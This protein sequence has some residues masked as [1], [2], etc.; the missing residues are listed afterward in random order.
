M[1]YIQ[2]YCIAALIGTIVLAA[3]YFLKRNY[4]T[5]NNRLFFAMI[6]INLATSALNIVSIHTI[7]YPER[8]SP[9]VRL[10]VNLVYLWLYNLLAAVF[11]LY[12]DSLTRIP[13]FKKP[14]RIYAYFVTAL[15]AVLVLLSPM[16]HLIAWFDEA[17]VYRRGVLHPLLYVTAYAAIF[18]AL[19]LFIASRKKFSR[20]QLLSVCSFILGN[21]VT[22]IFQLLYPRYVINNFICTLCL[23]FLF[24]AFEN[25]AYYLYH[26]T[27]CYNSLAFVSTIRRDGRRKMPY[28]LTILQLGHLRDSAV[29]TSRSSASQFSTLLAGRLYK[30][31]PGRVY[32]LDDSTFAI[33]EESRSR[34]WNP[35]IPA[36]ANACFQEPFTIV[37]RRHEESLL[38]SPQMLVMTVTEHF[39]T[40]Y[41]LLDF[42]RQPDSFS[43]PE[44][45]DEAIDQTL[46]PLRRERKMLQLI[47]RALQER[48][49]QVYYQPIM[50]L[51]AGRFRSAEAL[52]CLNDPQ[53]GFIN[54]EELIRVAES[55]GRIEAIGLYVFEEVCRMIRDRKLL[56]Q[57][58]DYIEINLSP[59]QVRQPDL[60]DRL[61]SVMKRYGVSP[62]AIN[63]EITETA[64]IMGGEKAQLIRF[65]NR[66]REEGVEFSLDDFGSGYATMNSLLQFPVSL[67]KYDKQILWRSMKD[68]SSMT[69][70]QASM[71]G[72]RAVGKK[73]LVEGVE[74]EEM[75]KRLREI[76]CDY[77]QG[78]LYSRP[79]PEEEFMRLIAQ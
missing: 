22:Q 47:D 30:A 73:V 39:P 29:M 12:V 48:S 23:F 25:Q 7:S 61:V 36:R 64:E 56:D 63:L 1:R 68:P 78:Y 79:V 74:T 34:Q 42:V 10:S 44:I 24:T 26:T 8:F 9:F 3:M 75:E 70:M 21:V 50:N 13:R 4:A 45:P 59:R 60:G 67:V 71:Q 49:F 51:E 37:I 38:L 18:G 14:V 41:E 57:G 66:M 32:A 43:I 35:R 62:S 19:A 55:Y 11:L 65:M 28:R 54:P 52:L 6:L 76:G 72:V 20:Y 15:I 46:E 69:I 2:E 17:L 16:T 40:G 58:I 53:E 5:R 31:F 27:M 33:L 77:L